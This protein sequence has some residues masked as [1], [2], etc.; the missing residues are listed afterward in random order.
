ME[1]RITIEGLYLHL[2]S[3]GLN[4][5]EKHPELG[6]Y[7]P[8]VAGEVVSEHDKLNGEVPT[9]IY[10]LPTTNAQKEAPSET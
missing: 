3:V 5:P 1:R 7:R 9:R 6:P 2:V 10:G 4:T 8:Q